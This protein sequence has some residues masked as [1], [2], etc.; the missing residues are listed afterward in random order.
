MVFIDSPPTYCS[1]EFNA[2]SSTPTFLIRTVHLSGLTKVCHKTHI[3]INQIV[4]VQSMDFL[5]R[6]DWSGWGH[7][8]YASSNFSPYSNV[9]PSPSP[10]SS[11]PVR[12]VIPFEKK[13]T[14]K[15]KQHPAVNEVRE[16]VEHFKSWRSGANIGKP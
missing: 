15:Q 8:G 12:N 16:Y 9:P 13:A 6:E 2:L 1:L 5:H 3:S 14:R 10:T 11:N 7:D 4:T